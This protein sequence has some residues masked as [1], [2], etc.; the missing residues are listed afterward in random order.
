M[1]F[2][3]FAKTNRYLCNSGRNI[4]AEYRLFSYNNFV[5]VCVVVMFYHG[6]F[7]ETYPDFFLMSAY[8]QG[9]KVARTE[10]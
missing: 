6:L 8:M 7:V 5:Y 1:I 4:A 10:R 3:F 2:N 9:D